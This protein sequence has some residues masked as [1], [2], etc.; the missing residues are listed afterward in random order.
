MKSAKQKI[1][2]RISLDIELG[3]KKSQA[4]K[5]WRANLLK[6][7]RRERKYDGFSFLF[8]EIFSN[9]CHKSYFKG[10][11]SI[12]NLLMGVFRIIYLVMFKIV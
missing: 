5:F 3:W 1:K 6:T 7:N 11:I 8:F 4:Q 10:G 9:V 12:F 2:N